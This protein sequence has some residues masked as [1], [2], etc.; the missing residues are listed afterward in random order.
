MKNIPWS[1]PLLNKVDRNFL[2]SAFNS[3]W[4]SDGDYVNKFQNL[5]KKKI[6][7]KFAFTTC[8]GTAAIH[9]AY[10]SLDLKKKDEVVVPAYGYMAGANIGKLMGLN[11]KF[12]EVDIDTYC[13]SLETVK[14]RITKKT[15]AVVVINTY[16][17]MGEIF[18][19]S[20]YLKKKKIYLIEDAAESLG[21]QTYNIVSGKFGDVSTLS[22]QS[23]KNITTGEGGMILTDNSN[24]SKKIRLFRSHGVDKER[25]KHLVHGHNFRLSNLL[26]SIGYS[27]LRRI[28]LIN[29]R[30]MYLYDKY[31][32]YLDLEKINLQ[33]FSKNQKSIPWTFPLTLKNSKL[34]NKLTS[35]LKKNRIEIRRGFYSPSRLEL[36]KI[37]NRSFP[38]SDYLSENVLCL[39]LF[40]EL[41]EKKIKFICSKINSFLKK[42]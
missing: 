12:C 13:V 32:K 19:I 28:K 40:L 21:S 27:Q 10:L 15:K 31:I 3:T 2:I 11:I 22:F 35:Y 24:I 34:T 25:Y 36:Y 30:K 7:R 38:V 29:K 14:K 42:N 8:N 23:T 17:N 6:N 1:K 9:L 18:K 33:N 5:V 20:K 26:A 4:I 41:N 16:G 37:D 39:P